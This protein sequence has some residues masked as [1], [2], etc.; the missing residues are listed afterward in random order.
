MK[1]RV[2]SSFL[3]LALAL[4]ALNRTAAA[5]PLAPAGGWTDDFDSPTLDGRWFWVNEDPSHWSLTERPGF[6]RIIAQE[7]GKNVLLQAA[8]ADDYV[9]EMRLLFEP[10]QNIQRAGLL[11][12]QD[13]DNSLWLMRAFCGYPGGCVGNGIYFDHIESSQPVGSNFAMA[14]SGS[15]EAYLRVVRVGKA[16]TGYVS[17]DGEHWTLVGTHVAGAGFVP[18]T[19][20]LAANYSTIGA[21][22]IPA[23]FD[24]F[25]LREYSERVYL[26]FI[27]R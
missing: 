27:S 7:G 16:Y 5:E 21:G 6:M 14:T 26:P 12:F 9:V 8:S 17:E 10:T 4:S 23:D 19:V 24:Y 15:G 20:G 18:P 22:E 3:V 2:A 25:A 13:F 1:I 11:L